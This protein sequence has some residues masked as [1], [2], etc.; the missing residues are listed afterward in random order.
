MFGKMVVVVI[1]VAV[2]FWLLT[3]FR[4]SNRGGR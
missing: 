4:D 1:V 3:R 2:A